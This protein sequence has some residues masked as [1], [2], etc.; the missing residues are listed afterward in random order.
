MAVLAQAQLWGRCSSL[1]VETGGVAQRDVAIDS[2]PRKRKM[3]DFFEQPSKRHSSLISE[4]EMFT[5]YSTGPQQVLLKPRKY[6]T[7]FP[8][9]V[10]LAILVSS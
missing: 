6:E 7:N 10:C 8:A 5:N 4:G 3:A 9:L 1:I 2:V